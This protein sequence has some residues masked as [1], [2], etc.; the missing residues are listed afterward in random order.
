MTSKTSLRNTSCSQNLSTVERPKKKAKATISEDI[1][2]A[3]ADRGISDF[4]QGKFDDSELRF[5]EALCFSQFES[6]NSAQ[7]AFTSDSVSLPSSPKENQGIVDE[8]QASTSCDGK[9]KQEYDEGMTVYVDVVR[10]HNLQQKEAITATLLYNVGQANASRGHFRAAIIYFERS[11]T[12]CEQS[13]SKDA[14]ISHTIV[15]VLCNLGYY[16]YRLQ[17][18]IEA[19]QYYRQAL[20]FI[21]DFS[22]GKFALAGCLNSLGITLFHSGS[23]AC[24]EGAQAMLQQSLALH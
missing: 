7:V 6:F 10:V 24:L 5:S 17:A 16:S 15:K 1:V 3:L 14:T 20:S 13:P 11:L 22:L 19:E 9:Q 12:I 21:Q 4:Y 23:E 2:T 8:S 18:N